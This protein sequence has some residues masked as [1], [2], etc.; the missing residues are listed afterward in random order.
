MWSGY[1][2]DFSWVHDEI[3]LLVVAAL[4]SLKILIICATLSLFFGILIGQGLLSR[5]RWVQAPLR[6]LVEFFRLTPLLLQIV[7]IYFF[8]PVALPIQLTALQAGII[9]LSL[10]YA[11]FFSEVFRAGVLSLGK[12]Q[13][14]AGEAMGMG[15]LVVLRRVIYP[16]A[17]RR[18][19]PPITNMAVNLTKDTSLLSVIGVAELFNISQSI[20]ARNFKNVE[21]LLV[22]AAF[23][24]VINVP[25]AWLANRLYLRE[26]VKI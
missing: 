12:G 8:A 6:I 25:L 2:W 17:L 20:A 24:L 7:L 14:E 22:V 21:V 9:A 23:Y 19:M 3:G 4:L 15:P 1:H 26:G 16:Q 13:R 11:A 18:M 10:N 5:R